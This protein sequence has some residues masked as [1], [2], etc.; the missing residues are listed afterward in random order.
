MMMS[1]NLV[2]FVLG[3][4]GT[5]HLVGQLGSTWSGLW[6]MA[7]ASGCLFV[8]VQVMFEYR[9]EELRRGI[10]RRC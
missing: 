1:A 4:D 9:E 6:F 5:K 10:D 7:F 8:G 2:G 3:L